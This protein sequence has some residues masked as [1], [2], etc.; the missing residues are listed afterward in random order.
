M[1]SELRT[2]RNFIQSKFSVTYQTVA[3]QKALNVG[4]NYVM[5]VKTT[6]LIIWLLIGKSSLSQRQERRDTI[7]D[8]SI[9]VT[10]N[11]KDSTVSK[12]DLALGFNLRPMD[13]AYKVV[14]FML[15]YPGLY[16]E[17]AALTAIS[18]QNSR[19]VVDSTY[20]PLWNVT[21]NDFI[22]FDRILVEYNKQLF[23]AKP[24]I[25]FIKE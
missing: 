6:L 25:V 11:L 5:R 9:I 16:Q 7:F 15:T 18:F 12:E 20:P 19:V 3:Q 14:S 24:F 13:T 8:P 17:A 10:T 21:K 2:Q 4:R 22:S 23:F 1:E